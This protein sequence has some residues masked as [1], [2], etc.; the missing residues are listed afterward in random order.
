MM[1]KYRW[2]LIA[3]CAVTVCPVIV[4]LLLWNR[5]P[6]EIATHFGSDNV[7]NGWSSKP[8]AVFGIPLILGALELFLFFVTANDPKRKNIDEKIMRMILWIIPVISLICCLSCYGIALGMAVDIG[9]IVNIGIGI[10]FVILGNYIHRIKQNY[11]VGIRLPWTLNSQ[12]N[13][14]RTH[15]MAAWLF[16]FGGIVFII[17][18]FLQKEWMLGIVLL[19]V[20]IPGIYSY[21]LYRRGI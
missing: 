17:N 1:K 14:N 20:F 8:F 9:L 18:G 21:I 11:T 16:I 3:A 15:R 2:T 7:A 4:G 10:L 12:E 13:W 6:E 5:L 19:I